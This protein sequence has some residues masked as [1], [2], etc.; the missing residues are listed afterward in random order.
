MTR[1][2]AGDRANGVLSITH[3]ASVGN[4]ADNDEYQCP[5][6]NP[7]MSNTEYAVFT[8]DAHVRRPHMLD[9]A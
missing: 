8:R 9:I 1:A 6:D 3:A 7:G 2:T 4:N 5:Y